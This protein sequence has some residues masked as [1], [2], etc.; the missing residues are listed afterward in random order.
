MSQIHDSSSTPHL[1][2]SIRSF[3]GGGAFS[4]VPRSTDSRIPRLSLFLSS[5]LPFIVRSISRADNIRPFIRP[6]V[7]SPLATSGVGSRPR[8]GYRLVSGR[9][10]FSPRDRI[11]SATRPARDHPFAIRILGRFSSR[12]ALAGQS[13]VSRLG[14]QG[15][16]CSGDREI[17]D[18]TVVFCTLPLPFG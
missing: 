13:I 12:R 6:S 14:T 4:S 15:R 10:V 11:F 2:V 1:L 5:S 17:W 3:D 8:L 7:C 9:L 16:R 18:S